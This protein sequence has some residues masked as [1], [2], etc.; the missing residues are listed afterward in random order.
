MHTKLV[1]CRYS[2]ITEH[3]FF[4]GNYLV[5]GFVKDNAID[6]GPM[7]PRM[8]FVDIRGHKHV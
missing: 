3:K 8:P 1:E 5:A 2:M 4:D 7:L 6:G